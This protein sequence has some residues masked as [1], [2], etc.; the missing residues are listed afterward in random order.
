MPGGTP[1]SSTGAAAPKI[2]DRISPDLLGPDL[3]SSNFAILETLLAESE[4]NKKRIADILTSEETA[5]L[6]NPK[7]KVNDGIYLNSPF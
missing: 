4:A 7:G 3:S 6:R 2:L 1:F 5:A